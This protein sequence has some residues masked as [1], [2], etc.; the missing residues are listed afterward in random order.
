MN[1]NVSHRSR[2]G[3]QMTVGESRHMTLVS[4]KGYHCGGN[5]S[6]F[7]KML[8]ISGLFSYLMAQL[9]D[10]II[11]YCPM[12]SIRLGALIEQNALSSIPCSDKLQR[13][14]VMEELRQWRINLNVKNME[15]SIKV[16]VSL[17]SESVSQQAQHAKLWKVQIWTIRP[18]LSNRIPV[19]CLVYFIT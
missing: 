15:R 4:Q 6:L 7:S 19:I 14:M 10:Y 17:F 18:F 16:L 13:E 1:F 12:F 5:M 11:Q 9:L 3:G 2:Y 8:N